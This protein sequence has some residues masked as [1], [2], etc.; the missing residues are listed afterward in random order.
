MKIF[1]RE[2]L[3]CCVSLCSAIMAIWGREYDSEII[4]TKKKKQNDENSRVWVNG[5]FIKLNREK[6]YEI[7]YNF[8]Q[9]VRR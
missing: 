4:R 7:Y 1:H 8:K 3:F 9:L 2:K 6:Y 5:K